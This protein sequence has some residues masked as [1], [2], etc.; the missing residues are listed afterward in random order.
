M[1]P[2]ERVFTAMRMET[3][4]RAPTS[5]RFHAGFMRLFDKMVGAN[6]PEKYLQ[7]GH[8]GFVTEPIPGGISPEEYFQ[9]DVRQVTTLPSVHL[10][11][12]TP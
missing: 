6:L 9:C 7:P 2:R 4:D 5:A 1:N 11:D 10:N 12:Y 3:P 8:A